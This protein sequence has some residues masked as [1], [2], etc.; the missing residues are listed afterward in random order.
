MLYKGAPTAG[1][2]KKLRVIDELVEFKPPIVHVFC[3]GSRAGVFSKARIL[4]KY[5]SE[6]LYCGRRTRVNQLSEIAKA[7]NGC[8]LAASIVTT[9]IAMR[10]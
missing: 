5:P 2:V 4:A 10:N 9:L 8:W 1:L 6:G 3:W 7:G